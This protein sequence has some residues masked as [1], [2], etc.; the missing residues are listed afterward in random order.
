VPPDAGAISTDVDALVRAAARLMA[1]PDEAARRGR[2]ARAF[3][4]EHYG[5]QRFLDDWDGVLEG[6]AG[7]RLKSR[8]IDRNLGNQPLAS[9]TALLRR[10]GP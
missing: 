10:I 2:V 3:A 7:N 5:L 6:A 4:L 9:E 8:Y 1:D